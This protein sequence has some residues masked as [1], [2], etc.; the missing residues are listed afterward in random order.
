MNRLINNGYNIR[1]S[2]LANTPSK[3]INAQQIPISQRR[4]MGNKIMRRNGAIQGSVQPRTINFDNLRAINISQNGI[5]VQL[6]DK[7]LSELFNFKVPDETDQQWIN[8]KERLVAQYKA[9]GKTDQQ[10][11]DLLKAGRPLGRD[12]RTISS[13]SNVGLSNLSFIKQLKVIEDHVKQ[14]NTESKNQ[15]AT[16][17]GL[18]ASLGNDLKSVEELNK[19]ELLSLQNTLKRLNIP[20]SHEGLALPRYI[21]GKYYRKNAGLILMWVLGNTS[22]SNINTPFFNIDTGR[23]LKISSFNQ[24]LVPK[25]GSPNQMFVDLKNRGLIG[26]RRMAEIV[27]AGL[28]RPEEIDL[29]ASPRFLSTISAGLESK[30]SSDSSSTSDSEV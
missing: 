10:I 6:S 15:Q 25:D 21:D 5:K 16:M 28:I 26:R 27:T 19:Q 14:G 30:S 4:G 2:F 13:N 17:L 8:E 22:D 20:R 29:S 9:L 18:I 24:L 12:Q 7:T 1:N 23:R 3:P 11:I